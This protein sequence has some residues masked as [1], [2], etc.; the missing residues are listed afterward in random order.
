MANFEPPKR[1]ALVT[2]SNKGIG[3]Q[4]TQMLSA[5]AGVT[6]IMGC[7]SREL[8]E[9]AAS[10]LRASGC[11]VVF[12]QLDL[13]DPSSMRAARDF[14]AATH[15]RL[16]ILVNNAAICFNDETLYGK[17]P[18]TPF[19]DQADVT[20]RTNFFGT[21][22]VTRSMLP[23]LRASPSARI[24]NVASAAGRLSILRS[25]TRAAAFTAPDL[26]LTLL[27]ELMR[28]FVRDVQAGAH[29]ERGWANTCYGMSKLG[30]I[31]MTRALARDE[32]TIMVN[33]V[34]PGFCATDQNNNQGHLSAA[35]GA[36]T[37]V[38][39]A[40]AP[41]AEFRSGGHFFYDGTEIDWLKS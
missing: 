8:G 37:P 33:S 19:I 38:A 36:K 3:R 32:P 23:L 29:A 17:V 12:Q 26:N 31:A 35:L 15:G 13:T 18:P 7:R 9:A 41:E 22:G 6:T 2:G 21:L 20:V 4:I 16:D 11:D 25:R 30:I 40:L 24:I 34:D 14:I 5:D 27:E 39:L 1:I 28:E 10:E